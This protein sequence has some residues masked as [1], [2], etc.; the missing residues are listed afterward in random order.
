MVELRGLDLNPQLRISTRIPRG[1]LLRCRR[2]TK[3]GGPVA[4]EEVRRTMEHILALGRGGLIALVIVG[5][6]LLALYA[7]YFIIFRF[8]K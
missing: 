7:I 3:L 4:R 8:G 5:G 2:A 6:F 1:V